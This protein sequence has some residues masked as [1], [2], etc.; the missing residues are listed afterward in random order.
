MA[1]ERLNLRNGE[2]FSVEHVSH[3][4]DGIVQNAL[5]NDEVR[6]Q[7][8]QVKSDLGNLRFSITENNLLHIEIKE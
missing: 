5:D 4:E 2:K 6:K 3:I 7:V 1:Y 8:N